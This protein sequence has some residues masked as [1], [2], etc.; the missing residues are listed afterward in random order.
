MVKKTYFDEKLKNINTKVTLNKSK[1][2]LIENKLNKLLKKIKYYLLKGK[3]LSGRTYFTA[4]DGYQNFLVL[5][6]I[7]CSL[8][9][10]NNKKVL[11]WLSFGISPKRLK[12]FD[13]NLVPTMTNL[14]NSRI[15]LKFN[16]SVLVQKRSSSLHSNSSLHI[17]L[18]T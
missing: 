4:D 2:V 1:H 9:L 11:S 5:S 16:K 3:I 7:L 6:S 15:S 8:I 17:Q 10:G 18:Y 13:I 12:Q 14:A